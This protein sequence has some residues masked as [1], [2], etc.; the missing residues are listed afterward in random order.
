MNT[1]YEGPPADAKAIRLLSA[2][3]PKLPLPI[4]RTVNRPTASDNREATDALTD[5]SASESPARSITLASLPLGARLVLGCR[6]DWRAA[7]VAAIEA[8][9]IRLSV[10]SP[11]GRTYRLRR[12]H[13]SILNLDG[14]IPILSDRGPSGW[15]VALARYDTRW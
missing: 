2:C 3:G 1:D 4:S 8:D 15:R 14:S 9:C 10:A 11:T 5:E 7:T 12:P 13:D 6:K